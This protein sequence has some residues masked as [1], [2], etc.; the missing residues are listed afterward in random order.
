MLPALILVVVDSEVRI[1]QQKL[2]IFYRLC[3]VV[4]PQR[5]LFFQLDVYVV[6]VETGESM[7]EHV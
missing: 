7:L 6:H 3:E 5:G 2:P 1:R 4:L